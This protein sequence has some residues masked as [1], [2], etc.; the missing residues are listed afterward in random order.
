MYVPTG[1][2]K[3]TEIE[4]RV[5][6]LERELAPDVVRIRHDI[7]EDWSGDP[8]IFFRVLLS[9]SAAS[10]GRVWEV[11]DH[12]R[13]RLQNE[14]DFSELG[15]LSYVNFRSESEQVDLKDATWS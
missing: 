3:Q 15:L 2:V 6:A 11:T 1:I 14:F 5:R 7:G 8:S 9:D 4:N 10:E 13:D 12:V